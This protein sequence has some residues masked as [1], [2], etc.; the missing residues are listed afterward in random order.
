MPHRR[1]AIFGLLCVAFL[2]CDRTPPSPRPL[3]DGERLIVD[4]YVRLAVL[5][6]LHHQSPDSLEALVEAG[7]VVVDTLGVRRAADSLALEPLRW[8]FVFEAISQRLSELERT[9]DVWW[10]VVQGDT[11]HTG[12]QRPD[13]AAELPSTPDSLG[14][15]SNDVVD[16]D[17]PHEG[18][19][20]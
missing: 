8:E 5:E 10:N 17:V 18:N 2:A 9:P 13:A 3:D 11:S 14:E 16:D 6:A 7:H 12:I 4:A 19:Q 15:D 20:R 1:L